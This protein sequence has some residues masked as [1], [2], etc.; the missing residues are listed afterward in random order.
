MSLSLCMVFKGSI[1]V[2]GA[3]EEGFV[4]RRITISVSAF[5]IGLGV[6]VLY[7]LKNR[8]AHCLKHLNVG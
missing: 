4:R 3:L 7:L 6:I 8:Q 5:P 2:L 1:G